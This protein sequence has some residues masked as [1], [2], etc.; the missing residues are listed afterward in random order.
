MTA[1][2]T[3]VQ[4][5]GSER[6]HQ[7]QERRGN[8]AN[9]CNGD[10]RRLGRRL[11]D[12]RR[13]HE[14]ELVSCANL[15]RRSPEVGI[16]PFAVELI[17]CLPRGYG[18]AIERIVGALDLRRGLQAVLQLG[19]FVTQ[20]RSLRLQCADLRLDPVQLRFQLDDSRE[21][22]SHSCRWSFSPEAMRACSSWIVRSR[23][24][25]S[26]CSSL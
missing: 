16:P 18:L 14:R 11:R 4:R 3:G 20:L 8:Q 7:G 26:G 24:L 17:V 10:A 21:S 2:D 23:R 5:A 22:G 25:M 13:S 19:L 6:S 9:E 1:A 15:D 12:Q